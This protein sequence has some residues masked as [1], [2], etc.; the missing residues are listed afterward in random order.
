MTG[1]PAFQSGSVFELRIRARG[2]RRP[3][4]LFWAA[5]AIGLL[6]AAASPLLADPVPEACIEGYVWREAYEGDR[7]CVTPAVRAQTARDNQLA[8][9]RR[10]P[11]GGAHGPDTCQ[12]GFVWREARPEDHVCVTPEVREQTARDNREAPSRWRLP[13]A[14]ANGRVRAIRV[15]PVA[16]HVAAPDA[17]EAPSSVAKSG[18]SKSDTTKNGDAEN[19]HAANGTPKN[20]SAKKSRPRMAAKKSAVVRDDGFRLPEFPWPPPP[21][22]T[23]L[24]LPRELVVAGLAEPSNGSVAR[25]MEQALVANGYTQLSYYAV[26]DGFAMVTQIERIDAEAAS[27]AEQRWSIRIDPVKLIPFSLGAY[28]DALLG[29]NGDSFRVIVFT[30]TPTPFVT[31]A[32]P[33]APETAMAWVEKGATALPAALASRPYDPAAVCHALVYEFR[34]SSLGARLQ[35][36]SAFDGRRHLRAAGILPVL[37][38]P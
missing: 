36:P 24:K 3:R 38:R 8:S 10:M 4:R 15:P 1:H 31:A 6:L 21:Y 33:V 27:A 22:S 11:D 16:P 26:P 35:N 28:L 29:K 7:V 37:E 14:A 34:I 20:G 5:L 2:R 12:P 32:T 23:R 13:P 30:F 18:D 19:G 17:V 25:R 9:S